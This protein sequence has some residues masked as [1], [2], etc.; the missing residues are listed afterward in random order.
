MVRQLF[1]WPIA[2]LAVLISGSGY[3]ENRRHRRAKMKCL[4]VMTTPN[5]LVDGQTR[6]L[7][8]GGAL[9]CCAEIPDLEDSFRL[10]LTTKERLILVNAELVWSNG[11]GSTGRSTSHGIGIRFTKISSDD[12]IFLSSVI[13]SH[14]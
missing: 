7:S 2:K 13:S 5:G 4:A 14:A 3:K 9:V 8:L 1:Q 6:N 12:R 11:D 10:V